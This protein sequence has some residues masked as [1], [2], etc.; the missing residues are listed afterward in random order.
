MFKS[1]LRLLKPYNGESFVSTNSWKDNQLRIGIRAQMSNECLVQFT[2]I[3]SAA[4]AGQLVGRRVI[5]NSGK[6]KH[7]GKILNLQP[8]QPF[9]KTSFSDPFKQHLTHFSLQDLARASLL[10]NYES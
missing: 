7:I 8:Y 6:S 9:W 1:Q 10:Q 3:N 4:Q 5:W 2:N